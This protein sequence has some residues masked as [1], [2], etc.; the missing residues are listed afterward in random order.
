MHLRQIFPVGSIKL[1]R[2]DS[3]PGA[4]KGELTMNNKLNRIIGGSVIAIALV[5]MAG[6]MNA[7][8]MEP[9]RG[10]T[11]A[12]DMKPNIMR[13]VVTKNGMDRLGNSTM[14]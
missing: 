8:A 10:M 1:S 13:T 14:G 4:H 2:D 5:A 9:N 3:R 12:K 11:R 6:G 7:K